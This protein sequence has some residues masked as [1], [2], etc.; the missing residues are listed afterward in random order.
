MNFKMALTSRHLGRTGL[1]MVCKDQAK[2]HSI[3]KTDLE[4]PILSSQICRLGILTMINLKMT[5]DTH[6]VA[7]NRQE[8]NLLAAQPLITVTLTALATKK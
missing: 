6:S 7:P 8:M 5:I 1:S 3:I 2:T 4:T